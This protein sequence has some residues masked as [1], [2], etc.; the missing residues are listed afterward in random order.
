MALVKQRYG[1]ATELASCHTSLVEGYV[2]EGHVPMEDVARLLRERPTDIK[3]IAVAGMPTGSPG[4]ES[5]D[6]T[7]EALHVVAFD[8]NGRTRIYRAVRG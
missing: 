2:F 6:G 4:M 8:A 1:V 7:R 3:D 5:P